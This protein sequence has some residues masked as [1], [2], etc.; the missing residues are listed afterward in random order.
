MG[1]VI[2]G[3]GKDKLILGAFKTATGE[4]D[5]GGDWWRL[6]V[7]FEGDRLEYVGRSIS[8]LRIIDGKMELIIDKKHRLFLDWNDEFGNRIGPQFPEPGKIRCWDRHNEDEFWKEL[9]KFLDKF[10]GILNEAAEIL[11]DSTGKQERTG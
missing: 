9:D 2:A 11:P 10:E 7:P 4:E 1:R 6:A 3:L 5:P 8:S